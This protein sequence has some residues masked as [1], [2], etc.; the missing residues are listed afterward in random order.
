MPQRG[1][2]RRIGVNVAASAAG[3]LLG[4]LSTLIWTFVAARTL[5]P[6]SFGVFFYSFALAGLASAVSEWGFD[7]VLIERVSRDPE[8]VDDEYTRAQACQTLLAVPAF[9]VATVVAIHSRGDTA[10]RVAI[11]A[12]CL[13]VLFDL[14]TDTARSVGAALRNQ[15]PTSQALVV[16]RWVTAIAVIAA[17]AAGAGLLGLCLAF[18][19][20]SMV[21]VVAHQVALRRLGVRLDR[22]SVSPHAL[23]GT[24][25]EAA[26]LG[27][28][29]VVLMALFRLDAVLIG[30]LRDQAAVASYS[31]AYRLFE[32][33]LFLTYSVQGA[34]FAVMAAAKTGD[35]VGRQ[36]SRG[37]ALAGAAYAG[38]AGVCLVDAPGVLRVLFGERYVGASTGALRWLALAPLCYLAAALG[39]SALQAVHRRRAILLAS[40][41]AL[42]VNVAMNL[43]VI[44]RYG[45]TGAAAATTTAYAVL[46]AVAIGL[47]RRERVR[48]PVRPALLLP[49]AVAAAVAT[50]LVVIPLP[51]I[52]EV[53][54]VVIVVGGAVGWVFFRRRESMPS[55]AAPNL[56]GR[57]G[58]PPPLET[59]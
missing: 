58:D 4:K 31:V 24:F 28:T 9:G 19:G 56:M 1:R 20:G 45:G 54:V 27:V 51:A 12:I 26:T 47:L 48:V 40:L 10:G 32:S 14:W 59:L 11:A 37:F 3:Q 8:C 17:L 30:V 46:A 22:R 50:A 39:S 25:A 35:A 29:V 38:F 55:S 6:T 18:L 52:V 44:P 2:E 33:T 42:V 53:P 7:P 13:A 57:T 15:I 36:L 41:I 43:I 23:G 21:G 5:S 34:T 49:V 16:Q